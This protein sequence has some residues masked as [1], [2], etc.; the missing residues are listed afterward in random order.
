[1]LH[2][3]YTDLSHPNQFESTGDIVPTNII[4][5]AFATVT[6]LFGGLILPAVVGGLAA[7][8]SNFHMTAK[9]FQ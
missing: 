3:V 4:E 2:I 8:I 9:L 5:M 6:I 7:Y 1:M